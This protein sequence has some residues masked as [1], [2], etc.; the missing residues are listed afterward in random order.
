LIDGGPE[1]AVLRVAPVNA[2]LRSAVCDHGVGRQM[3]PGLRMVGGA[4]R[5]HAAVTL[6]D[7]ARDHLPAAD[8]VRRV[9]A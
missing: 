6:I 4:L 2:P 8:I 7:A 1:V 5:G 3:P 9:D